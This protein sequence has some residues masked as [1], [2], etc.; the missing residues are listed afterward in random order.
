MKK[1]LKA[2]TL[3]ELIVAIAVFGILMAGIVKMVEPLSSTASNAAVLNNQRNVENAIVTYIGENLRYA[4]NLAII[5]GG[6]PDQAVSK[7]ISLGPADSKGMEIDYV[8]VANGAQDNKNKIRVIAF[9]RS[10]GYTYKNNQFYGRVISTTENR[11]GTLNFSYGGLKSDGSS[12]QYL[13]FGDEYY[14]QGDYNLDARI[15]DNSLS[16]TLYSDYYYTPNKAGKFSSSSATPTKGSYE[17]RTL[18]KGQNTGNVFACLKSSDSQNTNNCAAV[19]PTNADIIYFVY[20]YP[21][22]KV[23][24]TG[25]IALSTPGGNADCPKFGGTGGT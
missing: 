7:F 22:D 6:T 15:C 10:T 16:L 11:S 3:V 19:G 2:F 5:E 4:S 25:V 20:T 12:N 13:V 14:A 21:N 9:D 1:K 24:N 18:S 8:N 17:L 23:T